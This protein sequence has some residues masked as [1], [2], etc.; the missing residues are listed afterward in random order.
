MVWASERRRCSS[1]AFA[2]DR[3]VTWSSA[4]CDLAGMDFWKAKVCT[5]HE[6]D[7]FFEDD[8]SVLVFVDP[9]TVCFMPFVPPNKQPETGRVAHTR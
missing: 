4:D 6:I 8:P 9:A 7:V 2:H 3:I 1:S 5:E